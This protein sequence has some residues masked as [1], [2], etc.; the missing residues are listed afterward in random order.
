MRT[1]D[2]R[3]THRGQPAETPAPDCPDR[4]SWEWGN[5]AGDTGR[6][7]PALSEHIARAWDCA[8]TPLARRCVGPVQLVTTKESTQ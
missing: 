5:I 3:E 1:D 2:P 4:T 8:A 7:V 6:F